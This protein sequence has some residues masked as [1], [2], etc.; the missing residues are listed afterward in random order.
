MTPSRQEFVDFWF[1][2][3]L[4]CTLA[5]LSGTRSEGSQNL[6]Q[7]VPHQELNDPNLDCESTTLHESWRLDEAL[8]T[9]TLIPS[10]SDQ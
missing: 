8:G 3:P 1:A 10:N 7:T 4:H 6:G 2:R 9:Q 5:L